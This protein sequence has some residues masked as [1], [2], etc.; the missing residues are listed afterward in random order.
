[1]IGSDPDDWYVGREAFMIGLKAELDA[2]PSGYTFEILDA[3]A[4]VEGS[5]GWFVGK[6]KMGGRI[7]FRWTMVFQ[8]KESRWEITQMH[9]SIAVPNS[10]IQQ[11]LES[12]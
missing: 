1:M 2:S 4:Y 12:Y 7:P 5:A 9:V 6:V 11:V 10:G 8:N 3:K